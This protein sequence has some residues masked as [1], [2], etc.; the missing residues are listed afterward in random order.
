MSVIIGEDEWIFIE[1][2]W[3]YLGGGK[4]FIGKRLVQL[5]KEKG[6][7]NICIVSRKSDGSANTV[8]WV[9]RF[10]DILPEGELD[11]F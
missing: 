6:F 2:L 5:L 8:T 4:G 3:F 10:F 1:N 11:E 7:Q 9:N